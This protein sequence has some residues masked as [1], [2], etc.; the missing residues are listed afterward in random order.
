MVNK[1]Q[2]RVQTQQKPIATVTVYMKQKN[3]G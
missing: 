3:K 2:N 1:K